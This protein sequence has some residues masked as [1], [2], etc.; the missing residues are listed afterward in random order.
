MFSESWCPAE[1]SG[2]IRTFPSIF[3]EKLSI[4]K[5]GV[6]KKK[7]VLRKLGLKKL[8]VENKIFFI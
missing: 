8:F 2:I 7:P 1:N 6:S 4:F 3:V 5:V